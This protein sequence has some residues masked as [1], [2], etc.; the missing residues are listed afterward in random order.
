MALTA[1]CLILCVLYGLVLAI[2]FIGRSVFGVS[3]RLFC[4]EAGEEYDENWTKAEPSKKIKEPQKKTGA[5]KSDT[6]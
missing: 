6:A 5:A 1:A 3:V 2:L 4:R